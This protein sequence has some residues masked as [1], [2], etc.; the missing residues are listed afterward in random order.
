MWCSV[1]VIVILFQYWFLLNR[2]RSYFMPFLLVYTINT[3]LN[4]KRKDILPK[5]LL[6]L[7]LMI[8][9]ILFISG[10]YIKG[11]SQLSHTNNIST[12]F[13]RLYH[14]EA[15][16]KNRQMKEATIYWEKDYLKE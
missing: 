7:T 11:L 14:S 15:F 4:T 10:N 1:A 6:V 9:S 16:L 13:A 2:I 5:Q 12:V 8:Y 3:L